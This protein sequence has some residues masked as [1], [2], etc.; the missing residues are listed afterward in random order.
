MP[1]LSRGGVPGGKR[2]KNKS[3]RFAHT[4]RPGA[5]AFL[6]AAR[7][8][9][10]T[11]LAEEVAVGLVLNGHVTFEEPGE[12]GGIDFHTQIVMQGLLAAPRLKDR[13]SHNQRKGAEGAETQRV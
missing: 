2:R 5:P 1:F 8:Q 3:G 6:S 10:G 4:G 13:A 7:L 12:N 9:V 11:V